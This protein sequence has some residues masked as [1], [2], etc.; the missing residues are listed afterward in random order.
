MHYL[1]LNTLVLVGALLLAPCIGLHEAYEIRGVRTWVYVSKFCFMPK[2]GKPTGVF[3]YNVTF[4]SNTSLAWQVYYDGSESW[5]KVR[6]GDVSINCYDK[7]N[8]AQTKDNSFP[9]ST[10]PLVKVVKTDQALL[11]NDGT[12]QVS[13]E[14]EFSS[15][16]PRWFYFALSNCASAVDKDGRVAAHYPSAKEFSIVA[17]VS[18]TML[19]GDGPERHFSADDFGK[20]TLY[21]LFFTL[22]VLLSLYFMY[23]TKKLLQRQMFHHTVKLLCGAI[24]MEA[25]SLFWGLLYQNHYAVEG[26]KL[27]FLEMLGRLFHAGADIL[28]VLFLLLIAKGWSVVRKKISATGRVKI[29]VFGTA[30]TFCYYGALVWHFSVQGDPSKVTYFYDSPWGGFIQMFRCIG[31][32]WFTYACRTTWVNYTTKRNF[33]R[34]FYVTGLV[35]MASLPLQVLFANNILELWYRSVF[36]T[37]MELSLNAIVTIWFAVLFMPNQYNKNFPFHAKTV[38]MEEPLS[39]IALSRRGRT[40]AQRENDGKRLLS[41]S[42][43]SNRFGNHNNKVKDTINSQ[44]EAAGTEGAQSTPIPEA[45]SGFTET[46]FG[47]KF[48]RSKPHPPGIHRRTGKSSVSG[49]LLVGDPIQRLGT[50]IKQL[51]SKISKLYDISD[52][53]EFVY[54][55]L[56]APA[57][58]FDH[59]V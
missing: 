32:A 31:I 28:L 5:D 44:D 43:A 8:L 20:L 29:A 38:Q 4:P 35:W 21:Q 18:L 27:P 54:E 10:H 42:R 25:I 36:V 11:G 48:E 46:E 19:N 6:K 49:G 12:R 13:S 22:Y 34:V 56:L 59:D 30:Y 45:N 26:Y 7:V 40:S 41:P 2:S 51:R 37:A 3:K 17:D 9:L 23:A 33:Y 16:R 24:Y 15:N 1:V 53:V 55:E 50:S 14:L 52:D 47:P 39:M 57:E 58:E